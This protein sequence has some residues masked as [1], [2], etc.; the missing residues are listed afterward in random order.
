MAELA[1]M[2]TNFTFLRRSFH[3]DVAGRE[4]D[5]EVGRIRAAVG[6]ALR[7]T[8]SRV[9]ADRLEFETLVSELSGERVG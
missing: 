8:P 3:A 1:R 2:D 9:A 6:R 7:R 5:V 4:L